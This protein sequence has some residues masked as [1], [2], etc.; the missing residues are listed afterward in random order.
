MSNPHKT[1][2]HKPMPLWLICLIA[3]AA[4]FAYSA[5]AGYNDAPDPAPAIYRSV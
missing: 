5:W 2:P 1:G 3:A 4:V